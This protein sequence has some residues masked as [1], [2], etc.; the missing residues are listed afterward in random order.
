MYDD[1]KADILI[2]IIYCFYSCKMQKMKLVYLLF[3]IKLN[4]YTF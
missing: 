4:Y 3:S 1:Y 2:K